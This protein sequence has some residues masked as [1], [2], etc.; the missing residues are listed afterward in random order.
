MGMELEVDDGYH[1]ATY[2]QKVTEEAGDFIY[3]KEDGSLGTE[4]FEMVS[5]PATLNWWKENEGMLDRIIGI[6]KEGGFKSHDAGTCGL[7]IHVNR[8]YLGDGESSKE[9]ATIAKIILL[10]TKHWGN[11][12]KFSR[13][14][15]DELNH[16]AK[17]SS[18]L[19]AESESEIL[20]TIKNT[21]RGNNDRYHAV[22]LTNYA[23]VEFRIF[24]GSLVKETILATLELVSNLCNFAKDK[25]VR[26]CLEAEWNDFAHYVD[27]PEIKSYC[28]R[29]GI[30]SDKGGE[31]EKYIPIVPKFCEGELV[32][33]TGRQY[34]IPYGLEWATG[35][36]AVVTSVRADDWNRTCYYTLDWENE[37]KAME[38]YK[39]KQENNWRTYRNF[40]ITSYTSISEDVLTSL[41]E[42]D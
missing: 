24:R 33:I 8:A 31:L 14:N 34:H 7:H 5:H 9:E 41:A 16:W 29:R 2:A 10:V 28:Q 42:F 6:C 38:Q 11:M 3:C 39:N 40:D 36:N 18:M 30:V 35:L 32:K 25:T 19:L 20:Q 13:R 22:N 12:V 17:K 27:Y 21:D 23:T 15:N 1:C 4:S 37:A 26:E